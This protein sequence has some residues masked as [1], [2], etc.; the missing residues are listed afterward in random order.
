MGTK[1]IDI[2]PD[3]TLFPKLGYAGY[4]IP[5]AIAE[6]VDNAID[7]KVDGRKLLVAIHISNTSITV[8]DNAAGMDEY[9]ISKAM[10]LAHSEKRGQLGEFGLGLKTACL[11]LGERFSVRTTRAGDPREYV[12]VYDINDWIRASGAWEIPLSWTLANESDH[13]TIVEVTRLKKFYPN[14][15]NYIRADL[16]KRFAPFIANGDMEIAVNKHKCRS[17]V[18]ELLDDART[19]FSVALRSG[20]TV[21]GWYGLLKQGSNKGLYGFTTYRRGRM[22]TAHDKIAIGEHPTI[23]R[24]VGEIHMDHVPVTTTKREFEKDSHE[25]REVE[26]ALKE[27][28][29]E[30]V[31]LARQKAGEERVTKQVTEELERWKEDIADAIN[32]DEFRNYTARFKGLDQKRDSGGETLDKVDVEKREPAEIPGKSK[33]EG[34]TQQPRT[35]SETQ[36]R[37]RHVVRIK[38]KNVRFEHHYS[39]LGE[40]EGW[41]RWQYTPGK[42]IEIYTNTD[43]PAFHATRDRVFYAVVHIAEA[44]AEVLVKEAEEDAANIDE[45]KELLLRKASSVRM[46]LTA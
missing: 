37:R 26:E 10:V 41:K 27:E 1:T 31:R 39:Q 23:S 13:Y 42:L 25:Y 33:K 19:D 38:G 30:I 12:I 21:S 16:E 18:L 17:P 22:I 5:Q 34:D 11:S 36:E 15:H 7:A 46:E 24:I 28:F 40:E 20:A 6:L 4:S 43:F 32:S 2:T 29:R 35:P 3:R 44:I 14:L 45:I 8:A 9:A